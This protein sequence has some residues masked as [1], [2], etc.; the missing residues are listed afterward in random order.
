LLQIALAALAVD[1]A[2]KIAV[3]V[4]GGSDS[5]ASLHLMARAALGHAVHAVTV[6]HALRRE[7]AAEAEAVG[8]VC[9]SWGLP[10]QVLRWEHDVIAGNVMDAARRARYRLMADWAAAQGVS[11]IILGHTADDQ[12]ETFLMELGRQS[13]LDGLT[14]MQPHWTQGGVQFL[15]PFLGV[16]RCALRA[17]LTRHG[18]GWIDDPSNDNDRYTRVKARRAVAAL[19]PLGIT[20]QGL[21]AVMANLRAAQAVVGDATQQAAGRLCQCSAGE[22]I[23]DRTAWQTTAIE[24]QRRLLIAALRWISGA[25]YAPRGAAVSRVLQAVA[26]GQDATLAGCLI[27][28]R[29]M[30]IR[31]VREPKA[32]AVLESLPDMLWD[33]RWLV[34]GPFEAGFTIRALGAGGLRLC[35]AWKETGHSRDSL[36]VSPAVWYGETLIAAPLAGFGA[37][38]IGEFSARIVAPFTHFILSH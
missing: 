8:R 29:S 32:V 36:L 3:A 33:G 16:T 9:A 2:S 22:A 19:Q 23:F 38:D 27:R 24:V 26:Q 37:K 14:G 21:G 25:G 35:K 1:P 4:S 6:D 20:I 5:I 12:A 11:H 34:K 31:V 13:G 18:I 17:Y 10:H 30:Q 28:V 15:R 7:S